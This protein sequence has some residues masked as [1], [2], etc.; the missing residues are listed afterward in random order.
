[1]IVVLTNRQL[2]HALG[3]DLFE[4]TLMSAALKDPE[5]QARLN[6]AIAADPDLTQRFMNVLGGSAPF[7]TLFNARTMGMALRQ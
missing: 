6:R 3:H 2:H 4:Y 5:P 7:R 1:V